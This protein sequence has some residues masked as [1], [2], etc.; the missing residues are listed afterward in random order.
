MDGSTMLIGMIPKEIVSGDLH[1]TRLKANMFPSE[2]FP[3]TICCEFSSLRRLQR[4]VSK[5]LT[6][7]YRSK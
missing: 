6:S 4:V 3:A 1:R 2:V 7:R 5:S